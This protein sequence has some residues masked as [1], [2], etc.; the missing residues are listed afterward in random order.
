MSEL[1]C[2][3][4]VKVWGSSTAITPAEL[5]DISEALDDEIDSAISSV[6]ARFADVQVER[7]S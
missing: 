6:E 5:D 3:V 4:T 2:E 1:L 7:H